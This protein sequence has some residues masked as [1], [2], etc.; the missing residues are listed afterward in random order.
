M[1]E[2]VEAPPE[3]TPAEATTEKPSATPADAPAVELGDSTLRN[4]GGNPLTED[5]LEDSY[6]EQPE[7][8]E[9]AP[10]TDAEEPAEESPADFTDDEK[11]LLKRCK[12]NPESPTLKGLA[13]EERTKFLAGLNERVTF[14]DTKSSEAATLKGQVADLQRQLE[15][16]RKEPQQREQQKDA[17]GGKAEQSTSPDIDKAWEAAGDA[18]LDPEATPKLRGAIDAMIAAR[19]RTSGHDERLTRP[20]LDALNM[21]EDLHFEQGLSAFDAPQGVDK[22]ADDVR[23][24]VRDEAYLIYRLERERQ[25]EKFDP[26]KFTFRHATQRAAS[27]LFNPNPTAARRHQRSEQA[28]RARRGSPES[29]QRSPSTRVIA[30]EEEREDKWLDD[31]DVK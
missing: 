14:A 16:L 23:E 7:K 20:L 5:E 12:L 10:K 3:A 24:K 15:E 8:S 2:T 19:I 25:G 31:H 6:F 1:P 26:R 17:S 21:L 29:G 11:K 18:L 13:G 28:L 22:D 27:L 30:N 9:S 4:R